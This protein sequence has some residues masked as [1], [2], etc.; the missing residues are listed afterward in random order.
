MKAT[1]SRNEPATQNDS[2]NSFL[3]NSKASVESP[4][5]TWIS[6]R[7]SKGGSKKPKKQPDE[8]DAFDRL[9]YY[10]PYF[11][12]LLNPDQPDVTAAALLT[13][14]A[15]W[16]NSRYG[17]KKIDGRRYAYRSL[18]DLTVDCPYLKKSS[19]R[20]ALRR[21][22]NALGADFIIRK[23]NVFHFSIG[24]QT[25]EL[26]TARRKTRK[27]KE[28]EKTLKFSFSPRDAKVL[29]SIRSAVLLGNLR[30]QIVEFTEPLKDD[31]GN[32][33]GEL[34]P[35]VLS[36]ILGFSDDTISRSLVEL[37][38][39]GHL[40]RHADQVTFYALREGFK[41]ENTGFNDSAKVHTITAKVHTITAEVHRHA[42]EVNSDHV[43]K[44]SECIVNQCIASVEKVTCINECLNEDGNE[45]IKDCNMTE[46]AS[47]LCHPPLK[48]KGLKLLSDWADDKLSKMRSGESRKTEP[49]SVHQD[50]LPYDLIDPH[51]MAYD[52]ESE[53]HGI[54]QQDLN[55]EIAILKEWFRDE[56][57]KVTVEDEAKFRRFF[58]DNSKI[59]AW[60]LIELYG[61][62]TNPLNILNGKNWDNHETGILKKARTPK[63]FL[64]YMPQIIHL[65]NWDGEEE[66]K[67]VMIGP[68]FDGLNYA[69]LGKAPNSEIV[70][71][72]DG[73]MPIEIVED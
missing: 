34:R 8:P 29:Q 44:P 48:S 49:A 15:Y 31:R 47:Q 67:D 2:H 50:E 32:I 12:K 6:N 43:P 40:V 70:F 45:C 26:L 16:Q 3:T 30:Y 28:N 21:L 71:M 22:E 53:G 1:Q 64:R 36:R 41:P 46:P 54:L 24:Q 59:D 57:H 65:L 52:F 72:D 11:A 19:I 42:A 25:M 61:Q 14:I 4:A 51:G 58:T 10:S 62:M 68:P 17:V 39:M 73:P 7:S 35:F 9:H 63:Q 5:S 66:H 18:T 38:E 37:C 69:Y 33:Y 60:K 13:N 20:K 56:G 27:D 23:E 55:N